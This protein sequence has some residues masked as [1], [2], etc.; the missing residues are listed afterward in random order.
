MH[1][2]TFFF[3]GQEILSFTACQ[4]FPFDFRFLQYLYPLKQ[5]E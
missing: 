3:K 2:I 1:F 5:V 4:F